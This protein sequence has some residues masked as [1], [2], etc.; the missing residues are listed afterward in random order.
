MS[1][2]SHVWHR[3]PQAAAMVQFVEKGE[4]LLATGRDGDWR[5]GC[6]DGTDC[7]KGGDSSLVP[8][9]RDRG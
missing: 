3:P 2:P 8:T 1:G 6:P 9:R 4:N 5:R 7:S